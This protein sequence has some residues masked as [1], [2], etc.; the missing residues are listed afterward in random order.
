MRTLLVV[1]L[2]VLAAACG[3]GQADV[4]AGPT[5]TPAATA[6]GIPE[7]L[8]FSATTIDGRTVQGADYAGQDLLVWFWAPW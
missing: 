4:A 2:V 3:A 7:V 1:L 5:A 6:P 8:A